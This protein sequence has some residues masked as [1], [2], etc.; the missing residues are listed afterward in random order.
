MPRM[1]RGTPVGCFL[2]GDEYESGF[3]A[4]HVDFSGLYERVKEINLQKKRYISLHKYAKS[5]M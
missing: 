3:A 1:K 5:I 4:S 2:G